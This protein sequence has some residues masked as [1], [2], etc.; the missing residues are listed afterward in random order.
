MILLD[1]MGEPVADYDLP[2]PTDPTII[3]FYIVI[4][5]IAMFLLW[6]FRSIPIIGWIWK[7]VCMF[8]TVLF[9]TLFANYAKKEI[10]AWWNKD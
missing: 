5:F 9:L 4:F 3:Q 7:I 10:K 6:F 8:F 2:L 1:V